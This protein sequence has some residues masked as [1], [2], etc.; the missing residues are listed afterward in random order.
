MCSLTRRW[1]VA[2]A[3]LVALLVA[4]GPG[5]A[6]YDKL[7]RFKNR[8]SDPQTALFVAL[9]ALEVVTAYYESTEFCPWGNPTTSVANY[10]GV[11]CTT[12]T[13]SKAGTSIPGGGL[14]TSRVR[15]GWNT[16]D[17]DCRLRGLYWGTD[18][19]GTSITDASEYG[20]VPGG[21]ELTKVGNNYRWTIINDTGGQLALTNVEWDI[22]DASDNLDKAGL[23]EIASS[24]IIGKRLGLAG[25]TQARNANAAAFAAYANGDR[26][27][28]NTQWG[29]A[30]TQ[31]DAANDNQQ[32]GRGRTMARIK[33]RLT[34]RRGGNG[35]P[36]EDEPPGM[37]ANRRLPARGQAGNSFSF[38][39]QGNRAKVGDSIVIHGQ[40]LSTAN[41][42][43][44]APEV[45][46][47]WVDRVIIRDNV[48]AARN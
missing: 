10:G 16:S 44:G 3:L 26:T 42:T 14:D 12:L 46:V 11:N 18:T 24:G 35:P 39:I 2:T 33:G 31:A 41:S 43:K 29:T 37:P 6:D 5:F 9:N 30:R 32:A 21:G 23:E 25:A 4:A 15:V 22:F 47:D 7:F 48:P 17:H 27:T 1:L 36:L 8:T 38:I 19:S 28:A 20:T 13:Y 40:V 45:L 34:N